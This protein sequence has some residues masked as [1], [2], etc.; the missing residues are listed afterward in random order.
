ME[1]KERTEE[2]GKRSER[3]KERV[4]EWRLWKLVIRCEGERYK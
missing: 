1:E 3:A 2:V 4:S